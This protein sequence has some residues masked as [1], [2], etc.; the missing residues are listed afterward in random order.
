MYTEN[1]LVE[2]IFHI[3]RLA[4][5]LTAVLLAAYFTVLGGLAC[6]CSTGL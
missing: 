3:L 1:P 4:V 5:F 2:T 6:R